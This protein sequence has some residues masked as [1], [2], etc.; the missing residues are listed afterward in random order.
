MEDNYSVSE[1]K[2]TYQTKVKPSERKKICCSRDTYQLLTNGV[3]D[4]ET[5]EHREFFKIVLLNTTNKVLG[6]FC[7]SEGGINEALVDLRLVLQ[8]VILS[9]AS[10]IIL[11]H[12]HPSGG[13]MP[14]PQDDNLTARIKRACEI[15]GITVLDHLI[16]TSE[17][18]Y[19]YAD[20]SRI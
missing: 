5:I 2:L 15:M 18:Y 7:V 9:N 14:S 12:N 17:S 16:I 6:V 11:S 4:M 20:E 19:S 3:Y 1:V 8:A 10:G 13:L